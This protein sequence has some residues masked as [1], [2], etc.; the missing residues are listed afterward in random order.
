[1]QLLINFMILAGVLGSIMSVIG[2]STKIVEIL[3]HAPSIN[4]TGGDRP[5]VSNGT[6]QINN[7]QF[8]YPS[9]KE[10]HVLKGV[11]INIE[12]NKVVALVGHSGCGKSSI[13]SM[14]ERFY[15]PRMGSINYDGT[16]IKNL[17][18]KWYHQ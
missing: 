4:T 6:V 17:E 15:D 3:E 7:V 18:P 14:I 16:D 12:K 1:M 10:V 13:I 9:K 8:E 2:A 11:S 5:S